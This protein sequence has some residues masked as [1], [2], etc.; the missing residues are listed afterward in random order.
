M[1]K[2]NRTFS[3]FIVALAYAV[4]IGAGV[5]AGRF[6][7]DAGYHPL[8]TILAADLV[9]TLVV[10][11]FSW[12]F[13]NT[14]IYDPY[15]SVI[16]VP[17]ALW[18]T[19]LGGPEAGD[20]T[21]LVVVNLLV[22]FWAVRLTWNWVRRWDGLGHIDWRYVD[23]EKKTGRWFWLVSFAGLQLAPT[24]WVYLGCLPL[25]PA[26]VDS[27]NPFGLL[28]WLAAA[29][30][31]GAVLIELIADNQ[32]VAFLKNK[33]PGEVCTVGLWRYS[34][35]P[36]YFGE[37]AFWWG[38]FFLGVLANPAWWWTVVGAI[39]MTALFHFISIPMM[40]KHHLAR[41]PAY[42][43]AMKRVPRWIPWFPPSGTN[44]RVVENSNS[45][46]R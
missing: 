31:F 40:E 32:L 39:S 9:C 2:N 21:R 8:L 28:N 15:W 20:A 7:H 22:S 29:W 23:F 18:L 34:R 12:F 36:N 26:L 30:T 6:S 42:A 1:T 27:T 3:F 14:S 38:I 46:D 16:P 4:G 33:K 19:S 17:I 41:R 43:G 11:A 37:V 10:F 45:S 13:K 24:L 5:F 25:Y 44:G 35:F